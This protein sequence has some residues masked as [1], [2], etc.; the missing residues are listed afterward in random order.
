MQMLSPLLA[1]NARTFLLA[2]ISGQPHDYL[3]T[4]STLRL[5][6]R[7]QKIQVCLKFPAALYLICI[8]SCDLP[9]E[10]QSAGA[11]YEQLVN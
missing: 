10:S 8:P 2:T 1:G 3:E 4:I 6:I 5:A 9:C 7:A 11:C